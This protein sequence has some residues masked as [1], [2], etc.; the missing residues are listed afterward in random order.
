MSGWGYVT[1][2]AVQ[3]LFNGEIANLRLLNSMV[4]TNSAQAQSVSGVAEPKSPNMSSYRSLWFDGSSERYCATWG[5][6][7]V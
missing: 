1:L 4:L 6:I 2:I 3:S 7:S 5:I